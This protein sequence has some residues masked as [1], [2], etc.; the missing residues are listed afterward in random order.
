[1]RPDEAVDVFSRPCEQVMLLGRRAA[2]LLAFREVPKR[3]AASTAINFASDDKTFEN[4]HAKGTVVTFL[5]FRADPDTADAFGVCERKPDV[6][7]LRLPLV[8]TFVPAP[9]PPP[10]GS[11]VAYSRAAWETV[12][13]PLGDSLGFR[14]LS[15]K[16]H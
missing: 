13:L 10:L 15:N 4:Y 7:S 14:R 12:S 16:P 3:A 8:Q 11:K 9:E 2:T 6:Q 5:T 1:M